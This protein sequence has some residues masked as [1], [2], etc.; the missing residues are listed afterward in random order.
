[1]TESPYPENIHEQ[2][3]QFSRAVWGNSGA[4]LRRSGDIEFIDL[5]GYPALRELFTGG[6]F[7]LYYYKILV[8]EEYHTALQALETEMYDTGAYVTGQPGIGKAT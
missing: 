3:S 6:L 2:L 7:K 4:V 8:R 1:M 5:E